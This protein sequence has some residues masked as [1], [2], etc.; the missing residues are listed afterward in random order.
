MNWLA[1]FQS[2]LPLLAAALLIG[3]T[4]QGAVRVC[5]PNAAADSRAEPWD[6]KATLEAGLLMTAVCAAG[7]AFFALCAWERCPNDPLEQALQAVFPTSMDA[8]HYLKLA[9][10]GYGTG[11]A[12]ENQHLMIVFFPLFPWL[13]RGLC[14]LTGLGYYT[15]GLFVQPLLFGAGCAGLYRLVQPRFGRT[16]AGWTLVLLCLLPGSFFF[17]APMTESLYLALTMAAFVCMDTDRPLWF[18]LAG[19]SLAGM[20]ALALRRRKRA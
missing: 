11:Q 7:A 18:A 2:V 5:R 16:A 13:V 6:K 17:A 9:E 4:A 15:V 3:T 1:F 10:F 12:F 20:A 14:A 8:D 19:L